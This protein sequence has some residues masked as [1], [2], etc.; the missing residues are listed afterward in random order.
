M[1]WIVKTYVVISQ[2]PIVVEDLALG[3]TTSYE[4]GEFFT[5]SENNPSVVRLLAAQHIVESFGPSPSGFVIDNTTGI[6]SLQAVLGVGNI[7]GGNP[8]IM[9]NGDNLI[10]ATDGG[11][12]IGQPG[13][14]RPANIYVG[15]QI[16]VGNT[17]T[18]DTNSIVGS[19]ALALSSTGATSDLTLTGRGT[20]IALNEATELT[21]DTTNQTI[22]GSINELDA[23]IAAI[24]IDLPAVLVAGNTTGPTSIVI[25][26]GQQIGGGRA[27]FG[28]ATSAAADG[29]L[30]AGDGTN[31]M[32]WDASAKLLR[33]GDA[34]YGAATPLS[35]TATGAGG[36]DHYRISANTAGGTFRGLKARGTPGSP[37][38]YLNG[39]TAL[40]VSGFGYH[41]SAG[42]DGMMQLGAIRVIA[43]GVPGATSA[44]GKLQFGTTPT[45][46]QFSTSRWEM[47]SAGHFVAVADNAYDIG[48]SGTT[49]PRT[50]YFGTS[51]VTPTL[52]VS[53]GITNSTGIAYA[54]ASPVFTAELA[55]L[56]AVGDSAYFTKAAANTYLAFRHSTGG[57]DI[58]DFHMV[59]LS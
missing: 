35:V 58:T 19:G 55:L 25:T 43:D 4:A 3:T 36:F 22:V 10:G 18:I 34:L 53:S 12:S 48:A 17:I 56:T 45:G 54:G 37:T 2:T 23:A 14:R 46:A 9:S 52:S 15:T 21:L 59:M 33:V 40:S 28:S 49:R 8:I 32:S 42:G 38:V 27:N 51:V 57:G 13:A 50:G 31:E 24:S 39:D 11:W 16:V 29:D 47:L 6:N 5:A 7:T 1:A 44:P 30:S 41:P 26:S 20:A